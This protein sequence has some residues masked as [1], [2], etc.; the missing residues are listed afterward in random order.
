MRAGA[1]LNC[2]GFPAVSLLQGLTDLS[3]NGNTLGAW[4]ER[5]AGEGLRSA[6]RQRPGLGKLMQG[7]DEVKEGRL[8]YIALFFVSPAEVSC[9]S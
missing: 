2:P 7:D 4:V 8:L 1:S 9:V 5:D 3:L 6:Q